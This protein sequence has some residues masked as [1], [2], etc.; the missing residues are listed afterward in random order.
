MWRP[1]DVL[2]LLAGIGLVIGLAAGIYSTGR[3]ES[4]TIVSHA[5]APLSLPAW[6]QARID[7][8]GPLGTTTVEIDHGRARIVASP[9]NQKI[10]INR[11]WLATAGMTV[12]CLPNRV[13]VTLVGKR[14]DLDALAF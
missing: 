1:G 7:I 3:I 5:H 10:C 6:Q 4:V 14:A 13:S 11:G 2:V 8:E 9:C 12:A